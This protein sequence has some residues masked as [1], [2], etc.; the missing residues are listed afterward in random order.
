MEETN[1]LINSDEALKPILELA[2]ESANSNI[3]TIRTVVLKSLSDPRI[4]CGFD[5]IKQVLQPA[6]TSLGTAEGDTIL[7]TLDLFSY[8]NYSDY[9]KAPTGYYL[10][11]SDTQVFKL[12]QLTVLTMVQQACSS[13]GI[14]R[15][16]C[17]VP[18]QT[19]ARELGFSDATD[20]AVLR[21]VEEVVLTCVY[22]RVLAGQLCQK[23]AALFVTSRN[24]PPCHPRDVPLSHGSAMLDIL[25]HFHQTK[26][27]Q[28][29][30]AQDQIQQTV[31]V[32]LDANR[33]YHKGVMDK[34]KKAETTSVGS[35]SNPALIGGGSIREWPGQDERRLSDVGGS[36][37]G[38]N[39][40]R[41]IGRAS[42]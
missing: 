14:T 27:V 7:R 5:E 18:Y 2:Q 24:G 37:R 12:R 42:V 38:S 1:A 35:A 39:S 19:L 17:V 15:K 28:A 10:A 9:T 22:A 26:L 6:L 41:Q 34:I 21:Q 16:G 3:S 29:I 4:F 30:S 31:Q 20:E 32:Q 40:S 25:K 23:S 13:S 33:N 8:G 36:A 11:L